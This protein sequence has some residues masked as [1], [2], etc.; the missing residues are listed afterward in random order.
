MRHITSALLAAVLAVAPLAI[1]SSASASSSDPAGGVGIKL[2]DVPAAA[3][4]ADPR[5]TSY[6]VGD[7]EPGGFTQSK[8]TISNPSSAAQTVFLYT[9]GATIADGVFRGDANPSVNEITS[10]TSISYPEIELDAGAEETVTVTIAVPAD[11]APGERYGAVWAEVRAK[12]SAS[13]SVIQASRAGVRMYVIVGGDNAAATDFTIASPTPSRTDNDLPQVSA[14]VT[15][16]GGRAIDATGT[17]LLTNGPG[18]LSAGPFTLTQATTVAPG[19]SQ[20][21]V[22]TL[23]Q[24]LPVGPWSAQVVLT[25]GSTE[26]SAESTLTFPEPA[27]PAAPAGL[28]HIAVV[29]LVALGVVLL[30]VAAIVI[31]RSRRSARRKRDDST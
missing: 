11:A 22:F 17:L 18:G 27:E 25:S 8:V 13:S 4:E 20:D 19:E 6:I 29:G 15:N 7:V 31:A 16:T 30:V 5:A 14:L 24:S 23:D 1:A 2:T 10:W 9:G 21:A 28:D 3:V 12:T 26:R